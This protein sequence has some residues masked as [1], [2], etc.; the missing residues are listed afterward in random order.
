MMKERLELDGQ[1]Q[2]DRVGEIERDVATES[3][4]K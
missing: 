3:D 1:T 4:L 2:R